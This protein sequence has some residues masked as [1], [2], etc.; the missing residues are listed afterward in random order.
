EQQPSGASSS[1][2]SKDRKEW[3]LAVDHKKREFEEDV[4][5]LLR[6]ESEEEDTKDDLTYKSFHVHVVMSTQHW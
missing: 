3:Q 5:D 4:M 2:R 1:S 6:A